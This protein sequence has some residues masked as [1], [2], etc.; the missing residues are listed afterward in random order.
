MSAVLLGAATLLWTCLPCQLCTGA[1]RD[2][3]LRAGRRGNRRGDGLQEEA[4]P[5]RRGDVAGQ[6]MGEGMKGANSGVLFMA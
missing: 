3:L 1:E 2:V 5:A 6:L 4:H